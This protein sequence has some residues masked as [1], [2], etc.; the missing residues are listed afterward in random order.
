M[1]FH[2]R[3]RLVRAYRRLKSWFAWPIHSD[4]WWYQFLSKCRWLKID[5]LRLRC[6]LFWREFRFLPALVLLRQVHSQSHEAFLRSNALLAVDFWLGWFQL[7]L[8]PTIW[9]LL[10]FI[11][12]LLAQQRILVTIPGTSWLQL[13]RLPTLWE[14][15]Q[16]IFPR[17]F[18][19]FWIEPSFQGLF[20]HEIPKGQE[21]TE[22]YFFF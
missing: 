10:F 9:G 12:H 19:S 6:A 1:V 2:G 5:W 16:L 3:E 11:K 14:A 8:D 7:V 13:L 17:L 4:R 18:H 20:R 15:S 21:Y 22:C